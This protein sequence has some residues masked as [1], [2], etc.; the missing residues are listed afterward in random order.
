MYNRSGALSSWVFWRYAVLTAVVGGAVSFFIPYYAVVI[1][2]Q[3]SVN[4]LY[5]V[6]KIVFIVIVA[7]VSTFWSFADTCHT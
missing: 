5:S 6:G 1:S 3:N 2:G 7:V 4:D